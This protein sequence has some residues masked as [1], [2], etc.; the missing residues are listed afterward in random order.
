ST[1]TSLCA[2]TYTCTIADAAVP[3]CTVT[4]TFNITQ[5]TAINI[6][7]SQTDVTC[8]ALCNGTASVAV[9]G[10]SG[11]YTYTWTPAPGAGQGTANATAMCAG[12]YTCAIADASSP[13]CTIT[14]TFNITEPAALTNTQSSTDVSCNGACD[15]TATVNVAGG[16]A[17]YSYSWA[18]NGATTPGVTNLC[19]G[20]YTCTVTDA[21]GCTTTAT[22][23]IT[24]PTAL[25][26]AAAGFNV[27]CN[28]A[29]D[30]QIVAIPNGGTP[31]YNFSWTTGCSSASCNS[32]CA[33]SYT[34][35]VTDL[36]GCTAT[37]SATVTE[38][39]A[40]VTTTSEVDA[41]CNMPDG[42][43]S[44]NATGGTGVPTY[45]WQNGG[46]AN[47]NYTG[48]VPGTYTVVVTDQNNCH[49]TTSVTVGNIPGATTSI[50]STTDVSCSG[51][52]DGAIVCPGAT[53]GTAPYTYNWAPAG[54][55][56]PS[57]SNL[58]PGTYTLT[59]T[60]ATGCVFTITT[61]ITEPPALTVTATATPSVVCEG[62]NVQ[63]NAGG[64]G[65][66]GPYQ[67]GWNAPPMT[68]ATQN[69][70]P[71]VS[72][73]YTAYITDAHFCTDST[74]VSVTVNSIPSALFTGD[75]LAGCAP[76][77]VNF[78]DLSSQLAPATIT[79]WSWDF[80]DG[81]TSTL[82]NPQHCYTVAGVYSVTLTVTN[83][84]GCTNTIVMSNYIDVYA[85]PVADFSAGPQPTTVLD[86]MIYFTDLSSG[87]SSWSWNFGDVFSNGSTQ[88]N[89][90]FAYDSAA[91]YGVTLTV[92]TSNGCVDTTTHFICIDPDVALYVPNAFTPNFDGVNDI[93]RPQ[94][95]GI[96]PEHYQLWIFDRWGNMI[97]TTTDWNKGWDGRVQ[98]HEDLCQ[99]DVYVWKIKALD[100]NGKKHNVIGSVSL[101]R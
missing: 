94:G 41:H 22:F 28:G 75:S 89:P 66:T 79:Q 81:N 50:T 21:N 44:A 63:L 5:P 61:T 20:T 12:S 49:D 9:T 85:N 51:S 10:G 65:G 97:F 56:N 39:A 4:Q 53:G 7:P 24:E 70:T 46:P 17:P 16:T 90:S 100:V 38:P 48:I 18:P 96:D 57:T 34:V 29:C 69:I 95:I 1:A 60:D 8:N 68:G 27:S 3:T 73:T 88:Q 45:Q 71:A 33:G 54:G 40:I 99:E 2:G 6:V 98:G 26:V 15:G 36:H 80:G 32:V 78:T 30:G 67:Y 59:L 74:T 25:T 77:C 83:N 55:T 47:A 72:A 37:A 82:Q 93:F 92:M 19:A 42:S 13:T 35:T 101:I 64:S 11:S 62:Q 52:C 43:A 86:P 76:L 87:A 23:T 31:N 14:Q 84:G 91:C 58:C